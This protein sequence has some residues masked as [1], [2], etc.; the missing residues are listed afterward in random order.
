[1][2][3]GHNA[4]SARAF[5]IAAVVTSPAP[6]IAANYFNAGGMLASQSAYVVLGTQNDLRTMFR[7]PDTVSMFLLNFDLPDTPPPAEFTCD[8]EP[9]EIW[10]AAPFI[11]ILES[12]A[13]VLPECKVEIEVWTTPGRARPRPPPVRPRANC[14]LRDRSAIGAA[15]TETCASATAPAGPRPAVAPGASTP[16]L[17]KHPCRRGPV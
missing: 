17:A 4:G 16:F 12:W 9:W 10:Q 6:D 11:K 7:L 15:R 8:Q 3:V 1:M 5:E 2:T 13:A 14:P